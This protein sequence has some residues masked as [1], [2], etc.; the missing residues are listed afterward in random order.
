[1][2]K[3]FDNGVLCEFLFLEIQINVVLVFFYLIFY[4]IILIRE[5][6]VKEV[7]KFE[8]IFFKIEI[9]GGQEE[10]GGLKIW[11]KRFYILMFCS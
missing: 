6:F 7:E 5:L 8:M 3:C 1:M 2:I 4:S 9:K 11:G 10:G